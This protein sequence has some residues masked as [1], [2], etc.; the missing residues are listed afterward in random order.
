MLGLF[1]LL[2]AGDIVLAKT[3][4]SPEAADLL[5]KRDHHQITTQTNSKLH[6]DKCQRG[7]LWPTCVEC[8]PHQALYVQ[9]PS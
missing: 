5:R 8:F 7:R 3:I 6:C 4:S 2:L 1:F 9:Y